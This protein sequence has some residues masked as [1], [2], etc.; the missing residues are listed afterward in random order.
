MA[1]ANI[2]TVM[3]TWARERS[4]CSVSD[5]AHKLLIDEERLLKWESGEQTLTFNQAMQFAD[6]AH[7]PFGYLF[8]LHPPVETLLIPDLRTV[9]GKPV[10]RPSA[11]L[12]DVVKLML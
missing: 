3:L 6:K 5:F 4:G 7:V 10:N 9:E 1:T 11:E 8:L 2:N 12:L